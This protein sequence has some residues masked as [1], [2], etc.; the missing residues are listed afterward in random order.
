MPTYLCKPWYTKFNLQKNTCHLFKGF[1]G[2]CTSLGK[3]YTYNVSGTIPGVGNVVRPVVRYHFNDWPD[4][5]D[6]PLD[7][8]NEVISIAESLG[9]EP[10][11]VH[12]RAGVGRTGCVIT[13][14]LLKEKILKGTITTENFFEK[15]VELVLQLREKRGPSFIQTERQWN[16]VCNYGLTLL[17]ERERAKK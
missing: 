3:K 9:G 17:D 14:L 12:C 10:T 5:G 15:L 13:A 16:L 6:L 4:G 2:C 8:F 7:K 11:L 1:K